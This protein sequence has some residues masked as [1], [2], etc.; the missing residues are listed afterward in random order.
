MKLD[1]IS[2]FILSFATEDNIIAMIIQYNS[3][4]L[5]I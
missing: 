3:R 5:L 1:K 4:N 2:E